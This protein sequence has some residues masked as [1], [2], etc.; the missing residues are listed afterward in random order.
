MASFN[1]PVYDK[2]QTQTLKSDPTE[3]SLSRYVKI[4][5]FNT[6]DFSA[7]LA[8][9]DTINLLTLGQGEY[10][11]PSSSAYYEAFGAGVTLAVGDGTTAGKYLGASSIASAGNVAIDDGAVA[12]GTVAQG[13]AGDTLVA[14]F[15]GGTPAADKDIVFYLEIGKV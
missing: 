13:S 4:V 6:S 8:Q 3:T 11:L 14:T 1:S 7:A 5:S 10:L 15:G 2:Q 12:L 9:N